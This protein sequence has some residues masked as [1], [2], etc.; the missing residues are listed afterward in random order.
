MTSVAM[1][2]AAVLVG[3]PTPAHATPR[4][5]PFTYPV[6]SLPAG[7]SEIEQYVDLIPTRVPREKDD[8][9]LDGVISN[10]FVLQTEFEYGI[11]DRLEAA[12]YLA[13]R[14]SAVAGGG[15]LEFQGTKQR[16]R[17]RF[18]NQGEAPVGVAGYFEVATFHDEI[19]VEEKLI[20]GQRFG[21]FEVMANLWL[22]QER[23]FQTDE[24]KLIYNPTVGATYEVSPRLTF[25]LEYWVRGR[26]SG[27]T[28][29]EAPTRAH[30]YLGPTLMLQGKT[31]WFS[32][33]AYLGLDSI[34]RGFEV[35][36][37]YGP[38]WVRGLLGVDL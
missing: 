23:Y 6:H 5:L 21:R 27:S 2:A 16:L 32:L 1:A 14:Q 25:G 31:M 8:G 13:F 34:S 3:L 10:R 36:A 11:T 20:L 18:L 26:L 12:F 22:E 37:A 15:S 35:N 30:H 17:Y 24:T 29:G 7:V 28:S 19:E 33:G 4:S 9:T 38:V